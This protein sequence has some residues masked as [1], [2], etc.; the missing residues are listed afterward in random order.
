MR[1]RNIFTPIV[2][3]IA[4]VRLIAALTVMLVL[5]VA[6]CGDDPIAP[7]PA[8]KLG[9]GYQPSNTAAGAA[10]SPSVTVLMLNASGSTVTDASGTITIA[11][12]A[13]PGTSTL[14]GTATAAV[15]FGVA[16]FPTLSLDKVGVGYTLAAAAT[17]LTG[18]I[19]TAFTVTAGTATQLAFTVQ[20]SSAVAGA[21]IGPAVA[22]TVRDASGNTVTSASGN[23]T[24]AIGA[25]PGASTLAGTATAAVVNGVATFSTLSLNR[26]GTGY[27][28]TAAATG[29]PT[30]TS[31]A[32]NVTVG[33]AAQ[34][35]FTVL[36][37]NTPAGVAI[38]PNVAVSVRDASGNTV[39]S[40][41]NSITVAIGNNPGASTLSGAATVAAVSGVATFSALSLNRVGTG[42]TLTAAAT[43][44]TGATSPAFNVTDV[45]AP[46]VLT[47]VPADAATGV[48]RNPSITATFSEA[49]APAT[50]NATTFTL[51]MGATPVAGTVTYAGTTATL[52]PTTTLAP[53][54]TFT[55]TISTGATDV[56]G[57]ALAAVR[58]WNFTTVATSATGP[59][60]VNLGS[61]GSYVIL[62]KSGVST[63]GATSV[64]GD[65]GLSPSAASF[66]TG[67]GL[68]L[69][70]G[71]TFAT[72][73]LVTGRVWA[74]DYAP[75]TPSNLTTAVADMET[76]YTDAAGRVLPDFTELGAGN[77]DGMTLVP[78]LYKW[79]TGVSIPIV[80]T[81]TGGANDVF[82]FQIGQNLTVGN[83]A[84]VT[85][86]GGVQARNV[87]WQVA[88][89][90][91]LGTTANFKG[92]ILG[93]TLIAFNTGAIMTGRAFAQTAVTLNATAI[94]NP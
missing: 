58:I 29:L 69:D 30:A 26:V 4:P 3:A 86:S 15:V 27:T 52:I 61:A 45:V 2:R 92:I 9:F 17:G 36:P 78:G 81:L 53:N 76:A 66:I 83:G 35:A 46:T 80:V 49:M 12:G 42:Y 32:F 31:T 6:G 19:S 1:P 33:T 74:S 40:A 14:S 25:N 37:S 56:A 55:A 5:L 11:I 89:Q 23:I 71:N 67:F 72:S 75:P 18:T 62:A 59:A 43:G 87:F 85:L 20:P 48:S 54:T 63:T 68:I 79:G 51:R 28:L 73:S 64:V 93:Q 77:I 34:L 57:N 84:M 91:T 7:V 70:A 8:T 82:I 94:T 60:A 47:T 88:G 44:L 24:I 38:S 22:V 65:I 21:A 16:T 90:T 13:N 41:T 10:I 50:L 39:T